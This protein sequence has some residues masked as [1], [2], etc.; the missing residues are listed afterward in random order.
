MTLPMQTWDSQDPKHMSPSILGR[1]TCMQGAVAIKTSL[2]LLAFFSL[3]I[4]L[5]VLDGSFVCF[6][7]HGYW[8][9]T[10]ESWLITHCKSWVTLLRIVFFLIL[11]S[12][13]VELGFL[14]GVTVREMAHAVCCSL[15]AI[16]PLLDCRFSA[17]EWSVLWFWWKQ[18]I[19]QYLPVSVLWIMSLAVSTGH[20]WNS[21]CHV[22]LMLLHTHLHSYCF[23]TN[24]NISGYRPLHS[25][26]I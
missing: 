16:L 17:V 21:C 18:H 1:I 12:L 23:L 5:W 11:G 26:I 20:S 19:P 6:R 7:H 22:L 2:H 24:L 3:L 8:A 25:N 9:F 10:L 13:L 4:M 14:L 15:A